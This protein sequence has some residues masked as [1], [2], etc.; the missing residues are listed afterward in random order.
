MFEFWKEMQIRKYKRKGNVVVRFWAG[1]TRLAHSTRANQLSRPSYGE[2]ADM[3]ALVASLLL[4]HVRLV[5][6][7]PVG[8][9]CQ[10][11]CNVVNQIWR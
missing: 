4:S 6:L 8:P 2:G 3:W 5:E 11:L 1:Y 10:S 7:L 9:T